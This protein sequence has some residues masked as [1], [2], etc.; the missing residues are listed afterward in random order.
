M[1]KFS[2][3]TFVPKNP[4]K[5]VGNARIQYRSSWEFV[6]MTMLDTHPNII[7]W[8]SESIAI[9]YKNPLTGR[10]HRYFPDFLIYYIDK[11][12]NKRAEM[13]EVK[14][15]KEAI[16]ERAKS[17]RDKA[18]LIVNT[19]KWAAAIMFCKKNGMMFKVM[20]EDDIFT[21]NG[22]NIKKR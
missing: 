1:S 14:P 4:Q 18:A 8:A 19:A 21:K 9:P 7:N 5:I 16:M 22:K 12:G 13:I 15:A 20:T 11:F 10:I 17:K 2:Q 3:G 6:F